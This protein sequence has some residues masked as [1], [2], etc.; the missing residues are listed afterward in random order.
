[1]LSSAVT[2]DD[3]QSH[4]SPPVAADRQDPRAGADAARLPEL[5]GLT[6]APA[7]NSGHWGECKLPVITFEGPDPGNPCGLAFAVGDAAR[8]LFKV[9][10]T[11]VFMIKMSRRFSW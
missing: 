5:D 8:A 3:S 11:N 2:D 10:P 6:S 7:R 4:K 1:V 9:V